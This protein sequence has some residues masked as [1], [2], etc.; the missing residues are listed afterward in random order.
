MLLSPDYAKVT[1]EGDASG[2]LV[3]D[4]GGKVSFYF[5]KGEVIAV[6]LFLVD[7]L[8]INGHIGPGKLKLLP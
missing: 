4:P 1:Y 2:Y 8:K 7:W 6:A 5:K 3:F